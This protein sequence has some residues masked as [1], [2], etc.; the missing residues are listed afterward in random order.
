MVDPQTTPE[1]RGGGES[2][3]TKLLQ[4]S[5]RTVTINYLIRGGRVIDVYFNGTISDLATRRD[6]F[7]SLIA[8][9]GA[10]GLIKRL[11]DRTQKLL[12][13]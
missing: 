5:G 10:D 6:E 9:G 2:V 12:G 3:K 8:S 1:S 13:R 4:S 7:S 11:R